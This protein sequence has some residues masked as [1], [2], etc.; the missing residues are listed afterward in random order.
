MENNESWAV[1]VQLDG[2]EDWVLNPNRFVSKEEAKAF[3][4]HIS[5][6]PIVTGVKIAEV[7]AWP[8][9]Q[10]E[11]EANGLRSSDMFDDRYQ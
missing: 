1:I 7:P 8:N 4:Q 3:V 6:D 9:P 5:H 10:D 11:L 2:H